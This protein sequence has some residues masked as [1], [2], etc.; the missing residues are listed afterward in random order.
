MKNI[1]DFFD[2][3]TLQARFT[4]SVLALLPLIFL[5]ASYFD[6]DKHLISNV[7]AGGIFITIAVYVLS[8]LVRSFGKKI[9]KKML[10][11]W[12]GFPTHNFLKHSNHH[13]DTNRKNEIHRLINDKF[14]ITLPTKEQEQNDPQTSDSK[15]DQAITSLRENT[16]QNYILL[17]ENIAYG[18]MRNS[19]G[20]KNFAISIIIIVIVILIILFFTHYP[21]TMYSLNN[22]SDFSKTIRMSLW[23]SIGSCVFMPI[24][25]VFFITKKNLKKYADQYAETLLNSL[26]QK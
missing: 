22:F 3:Y 12:G 7:V 17:Q 14:S 8:N 1:S 24:Y 9:E 18:F 21:Y 5:I 13:F 19:L 11:E 4:P 15:Y 10:N 6:F 23:L 2:K 16:R 25:W 26:F 20:I